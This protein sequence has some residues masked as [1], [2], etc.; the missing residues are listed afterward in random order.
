MELGSVSAH[1]VIFGGHRG[2]DPSNQGQ[3]KAEAPD[4]NNVDGANSTAAALTAPSH[5]PADI[6]VALGNGNILHGSIHAEHKPSPRH[7]KVTLFD[8]R[9]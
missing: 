1:D 7:Y 3:V 5:R 6:F 4:P 2:Q 9:I 8:Y